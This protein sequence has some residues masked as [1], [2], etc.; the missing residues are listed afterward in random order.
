MRVLFKFYEFIRWMVITIYLYSIYKFSI[1]RSIIQV[2]GI[3]YFLVGQ[4]AKKKFYSGLSI[5]ANSLTQSATPAASAFNNSLSR[6]E[7]QK[8]GKN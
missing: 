3:G 6:V 7:H 4:R 5:P 8:S 2:V 1:Y